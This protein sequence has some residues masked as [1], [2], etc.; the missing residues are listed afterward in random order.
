MLQFVGYGSAFNTSLG[1]NSAYVKKDKALFLIDCGSCTFSRLQ[2]RNILA[3]VEQIYVLITHLH[4]DHV[5]SLGDLIFYSYYYLGNVAEPSLTILVPKE[6]DIKSLL[7]QMGVSADKY[8][9]QSF[10]ESYKT[11]E[12]FSIEIEAVKVNHVQELSCFGYVLE[13]ENNKI[14]YSGDCSDIPTDIL[15]RLHEQEFAYFYQDTCQADYEGNVHLSLR[16]LTELV[17]EN[18]RKYV[19]CMHL[20]HNFERRKAEMLGFNVVS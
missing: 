4:P 10:Q 7:Q 13:I 9:L 6:I 8:I 5:G 1:N 19:Y 14:Y 20:D 3:G 17:S 15:K 18:A 11:T 16:K 2:E 12:P